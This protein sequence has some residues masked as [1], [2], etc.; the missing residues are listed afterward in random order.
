MS[1]TEEINEHCESCG[2][3]IDVDETMGMQCKVCKNNFCIKCI[4]HSGI[5]ISDSINQEDWEDNWYC[6]DCY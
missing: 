1:D 6:Y 3:E 4:S 5:I 2:S